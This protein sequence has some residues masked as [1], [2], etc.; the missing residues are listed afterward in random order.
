M[1]L[2]DLTGGFAITNTN[3]FKTGLKRIDAET[4]DYYILG[5]TSNNPDPLKRT[6]KIDVQITRPGAVVTQWRRSYDLDPMSG[7]K[8]SGG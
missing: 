6:R 4:S 3:D 1:E 5:Y 2:A 8:K 7:I